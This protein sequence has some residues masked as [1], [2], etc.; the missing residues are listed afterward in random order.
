MGNQ[1]SAPPQDHVALVIGE[2]LVTQPLPTAAVGAQ[3]CSPTS[4]ELEVTTE[5]TYPSRF[6]VRN[7]K[8]RAIYFQKERK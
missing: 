4:V 7:P 5:P 3:Y 1:N 6:I 8:T 2:S